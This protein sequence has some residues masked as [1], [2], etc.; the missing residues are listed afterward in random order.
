MFRSGPVRVEHRRVD[1]ERFVVSTDLRVVSRDDARS[2][3][4]LLRVMASELSRL[5]RTDCRLV[6]VRIVGRRRRA[7]AVSVVLTVDAA[8]AWE[9]FELAGSITRS[10]IHT[11]GGFTAGW[12]LV[13]PHIGQSVTRL[14]RHRQAAQ[15]SPRSRSQ[16]FEYGRSGYSRPTSWAAS[17]AAARARALPHLPLPPFLAPTNDA[18]VIDLR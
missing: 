10:A 12:E 7:T 15:R 6:R 5:R 1:A 16:Q 2:T 3:A 8:S 4:A 11:A 13:T 9:A 14:G 18:M 17:A